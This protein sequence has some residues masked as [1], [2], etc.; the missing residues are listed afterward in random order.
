MKR[1]NYFSSILMMVSFSMAFTA[2]NKNGTTPDGPGAEDLS[3][4]VTEDLVL[5]ANQTY[6]LSGSL[7]VK[8]PAT[9]TVREG[10]RLVARNNGEVIYILIEQGAKIDAQGTAQ[11]PVVMTAEKESEGAWGGLHICGKAHTNLGAEG[12]MSEIGNAP[13][14]G[15]DDDD[16]SGILRYVRLEYTGYAFDSEHESNGISLYGVGSGTTISYVQTYVGS[17]DGIEF[18]GGS[19]NVDH[20]VVVNCT[21]DSFDW[22][23]GWNG[24]AHHLVAYQSDPTCD[25]LMECDNNGDNETVEPFSHPDLS[26]VTLIG[27][28]SEENSLGIRLRAGTEVSLDNAVI[29]GKPHT[30]NVET[31]HTQSSLADGTSVLTNITMTGDFRNENE[32]ASYDSD[33]FLAATGNSIVESVEV[34]DRFYTPGKGAFETSSNWTSG[35]TR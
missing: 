20:C 15:N 26:Y 29:T 23:E 4:I 34:S 12:G 35:W 1:F 9:L 24:T 16:N 7:Q 11:N 21:D 10:A 8:A 25:C 31:A 28:G 3:G 17:D 27:N 18:F 22:T 6:Y 32:S 5:E 33:D 30:I 19:V 14:G 13:Y 2:C